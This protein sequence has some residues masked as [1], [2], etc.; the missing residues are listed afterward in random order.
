[1]KRIILYGLGKVGSAALEYNPKKDVR[2]LFICD[3]NESLWGT[4]V[5][6]YDICSPKR[7]LD[8]EYDKLILCLTNGIA[9]NEVYDQ[10]IS[11]GVPVNK[12]VFSYS[13]YALGISYSPLDEFFEIPRKDI[14]PFKKGPAEIYTDYVGET[15]KSHDRRVGEG[16]FE[17]YC[18]GEGLD[19]GYGADLIVP[20]CSGWDLQN[21]NAQYLEGVE[22]ESFDYVYSSHCLEHMWDVRVALKNWF[23]VVRKGGY[24]II[25]IPHRDLYEKKRTLPSR[26]NGDHKHMFL[27]GKAEEPDTLDIVEE[28]RNSL[29]CYDIKYVKTCDEG[30]YSKDD[31][32]H[33]EGE[34][35]IEAVIQKI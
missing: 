7:I 12:I 23:R 5:R 25:A 6:G 2:I 13:H 29:S 19:I 24:L 1:M 10:L 15:A 8:T 4:T 17:K 11:M 9:L 14:K 32:T 31:M 33:S 28:I 26:W 30:F 3:N 34:F 20:G 21:G 22:D 27:I 18:Q 16:F 35:Q